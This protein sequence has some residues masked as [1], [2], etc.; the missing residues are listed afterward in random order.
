MSDGSFA[1][2]LVLQGLE[3]LPWVTVGR[4]SGPGQGLALCH[5]VMSIVGS[6]TLPGTPCHQAPVSSSPGSGDRVALWHGGGPEAAGG[7]RWLQEADHSGPAPGSAVRRHG[8][9]PGRAVGQSHGVGPGR[10]ARPAAG[11]EAGQQLSQVSGEVTL[12]AGKAEGVLKEA[13]AGSDR[14]QLPEGMSA[15]KS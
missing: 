6:N 10:D 4:D 8:E 14:S 3:P 12:A 2:G 5:V 15:A 13:R 7:Q 11:K 9:H 1:L